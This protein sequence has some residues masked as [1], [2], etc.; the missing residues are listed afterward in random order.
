MF[1]IDIYNLTNPFGDY[2]QTSLLLVFFIF[3]TL[4]SLYFYKNKHKLVE[5][6]KIQA[7]G[8]KKKVDENI[9]I[10]KDDEDEIKF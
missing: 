3:S 8:Y 4:E 1:F 5:Q 2:G 6:L 9:L 10:E 7:N